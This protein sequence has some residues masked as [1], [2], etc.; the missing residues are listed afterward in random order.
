MPESPADPDTFELD[1]EWFKRARPASE[2]A[3]HIV[4]AYRRT[5]GKQKAPTKEQITIRLDADITAHLRKEGPGWQTAPERHVA[6][7]HFRVHRDEVRN[8]CHFFI[9]DKRHK[10]WIVACCSPTPIHQRS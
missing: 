6:P 2:M 5:R 4:E 9:G 10:N 1:E 7:S 8:S 3:P